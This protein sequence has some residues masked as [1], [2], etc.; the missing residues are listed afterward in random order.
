MAERRYMVKLA[1]GPDGKMDK[2]V[3]K[4][5]KKIGFRRKSDWKA[6]PLPNSVIIVGYM[7]DGLLDKANGISGVLGI[8]P[9][10]KLDLL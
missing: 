5:L 10:F 8:Y 9:D 1:I 6:V 7:D 2:S 3:L 4:A